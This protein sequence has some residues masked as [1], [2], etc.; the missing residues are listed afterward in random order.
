MKKALVRMVWGCAAVMI[1][2][3]HVAAEK[4]FELGA[5]I[6][7]PVGNFQDSWNTG[8]G[9]NGAFL[10]EITPFV[11]GG[12]SASYSALGFDIDALK[13][14][15]KNPATYTAFGGDASIISLCGELRAQTGVM[16]KAVFY[17]GAGMGLYV[18]SISDITSGDPGALKTET[19]KTKNRF[20]GF[21]NAGFAIP[22][23]SMIRLGARA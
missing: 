12:F 22:V 5:G 4:R 15:A 2:G 10:M 1:L 6:A 9:L 11:S 23:A 14:T 18:V 8:L 17:G 13:A 21:A 19:F 16:D 3:G 7:S 20:G